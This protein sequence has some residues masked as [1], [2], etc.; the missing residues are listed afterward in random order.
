MTDNITAAR[1]ALGLEKGTCRNCKWRHPD[2]PGRG[3]T[4]YPDDPRLDTSSCLAVT[5]CVCAPGKYLL[6]APHPGE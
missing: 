4:Y 6:W 1:V 3:C 5:E 2:H